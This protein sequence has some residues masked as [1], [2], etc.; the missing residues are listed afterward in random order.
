M[1]ELD[2]GDR[3][4]V[5]RA[6]GSTATFTVDRIASYPKDRFPTVEVYRN[7]DHAGL[8]LVTCGGDCSA[9]DSHCAD[10]VVIHAALTDSHT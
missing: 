3:I 1:D 10:N 4:D 6:G 7:L 8:R 2:R 5:H 9:S